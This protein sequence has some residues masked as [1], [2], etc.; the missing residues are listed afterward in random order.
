MI[1]LLLFLYLSPQ[2]KL[3]VKH[4]NTFGSYEHCNQEAERIRRLDPPE[5]SRFHCMETDKTK[6]MMI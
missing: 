1:Y 4:I 2:G 6:G 3:D 5:G